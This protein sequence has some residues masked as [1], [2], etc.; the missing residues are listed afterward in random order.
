MKPEQAKLIAE[1]LVQDAESARKPGLAAVANRRALTTRV[2]AGMMGIVGYYFG[3]RWATDLMANPLA[4]QGF[5]VALGLLAAAAWPPRR[6][7]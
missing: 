6:Q 7:T 5:A 4:Q 2:V 1:Q 3:M